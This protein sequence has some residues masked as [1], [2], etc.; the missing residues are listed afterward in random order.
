[1]HL[2]VLHVSAAASQSVGEAV[3]AWF[4][5]L[6]RPQSQHSNLYVQS[7]LPGRQQKLA[8]VRL[9]R[10]NFKG[11]VLQSSLQALATS[12]CGA[13]EEHFFVCNHARGN[14]LMH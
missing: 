10:H 9:F 1:M 6:Q 7:L 13:A 5:F 14:A 2:I 11:V 4:P 12:W 3:L 8:F